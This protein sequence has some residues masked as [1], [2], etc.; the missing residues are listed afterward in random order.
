[1]KKL[2]SSIGISLCLLFFVCG[3]ALAQ[4]GITWTTQTT[5][6]PTLGWTNIT[7]ANGTYVA[8]ANSGT[9]S[10]VMTSPDGQNWT[11]RTT[12]TDNQWADVTYG[13][14]LFV[15]IGLNG[16]GS[17]DKVMTSPDGINWTV[18]ATPA[19]NFWNGVIYANGQFVAVASSGTGNRV[20]TSPDG[21]TWTIRNSA[22]DVGWSSVAYGN[23]LYVAVAA[24][25]TGA[26]VM[27]SPDGITWTVQTAV[28]NQWMDIV[29]ANGLF[30]AVARSGTGNRVMTSPDGITWTTRSTPADNSWFSVAYGSGMFV[31]VATTGTGNRVMTSPDG[32]NWTIRASATDNNWRSVA[33]NAGQ[34]VAVAA[35]G[36]GDQIMTSVS[37]VVGL[38]WLS[39]NACL[40]NTDQAAISWQVEEQDVTGYSIEKSKDGTNFTAIGSVAGQGN[41]RHSYTFT[42]PQKLTGSA[43]YRIKQ[44]DRDGRFSYSS[45]MTLHNSDVQMSIY[46][47]PT[48]D[49]VTVA[50]SSRLL[51]KNAVVTDVYGKLLQTIK[52]SNLSFTVNVAQYPAGAYFIKVDKEKPVK[53]IKE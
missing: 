13:N 22:A 6:T 20:M 32:I 33:Y 28:N 43:Y 25:I 38:H 8:V 40:N 49:F 14:G 39:V 31:A 47:N 11:L 48:S 52:V 35:T 27:T 29:Y 42:E 5:P 53:I 36:T 24:S 26:K 51:N 1:M 30:V 46:P 12:P 23:G 37:V 44:T 45:I 15:A 21:I 18:R 17:G 2:L 4:P 9:G 34:F 10:R 19:D 16:S 41:G 50:V 3:T 7:Y